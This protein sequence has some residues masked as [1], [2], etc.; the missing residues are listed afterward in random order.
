VDGKLKADSSHLM[1]EA[2]SGCG[3]TRGELVGEHAAEVAAAFSASSEPSVCADERREA[4]RSCNS[5]NMMKICNEKSPFQPCGM[6][7][8]LKQDFF[9]IQIPAVK[10]ASRVVPYIEPHVGLKF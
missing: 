6:L 7:K 9:Q 8:R 10:E 5:A 1:R 3:R 2:G 4:R